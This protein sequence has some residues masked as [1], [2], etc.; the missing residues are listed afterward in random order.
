MICMGMATAQT[1]AEILDNK[2]PTILAGCE[3]PISIYENNRPDRKW[4]I[5]RLTPTECAR[6]QGFPDDWGH[7][8]HKDDMTDEELEFWIKVRTKDEELRGK[9]QYQPKDKETT[10][11]QMLAWYDKLHTD[12]S[13]YKMWGNGVALPCVYSV[14]HGI[15]SVVEEEQEE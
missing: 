5:R 10:K 4:I 7:L 2:A 13:E 8:E 9:K 12:T 14:L 6:L 11:K 1:N 3:K 15:A